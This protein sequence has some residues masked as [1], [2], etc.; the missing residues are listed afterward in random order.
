MPWALRIGGGDESP[1]VRVFFKQKTAYEIRPRDWSSDVC[2]SDLAHGISRRLCRWR[3]NQL[4]RYPPRNPPYATRP[5][6]RS[7]KKLAKSIALFGSCV[8]TRNSSRFVT[9]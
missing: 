2:S 9:M 8:L 4:P 1:I 7:A 6:R 5:P 3:K